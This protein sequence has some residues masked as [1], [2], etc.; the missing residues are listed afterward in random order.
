M[1]SMRALVPEAG[2]YMSETSYF[3]KDWQAAYWGEHY[4]RLVQAKRRYDPDNVFRGHHT[5]EP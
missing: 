3:D 5:V 4:P 2:T 1:T